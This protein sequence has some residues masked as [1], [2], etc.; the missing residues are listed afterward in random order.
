MSKNSAFIH[1]RVHSSYSLLEGAI[2]PQGMVELSDKYHM[3][4]VAITDTGN[5]FGSLEFSQYC[6]KNGVQPIVGCLLDID[7]GEKKGAF[8]TSNNFDK[9]LL[10]AKNNQGY[11]NLLELVSNSF[12]KTGNDIR[13]HIK[14]ADLDIL[15]EGLIALTGSVGGPVNRFILEKRPAEAENILLRLHAI[16]EDRLYIE[17]CRHGLKDEIDSEEEL[18][19]LAYKHNIPLVATNDVFFADQ[20]V[21]KAHDA[22]L[23]IAG[24]RYVT[25]ADR[26]TATPEHYFKSTREMVALFSD[27]PEAVEN[28]IN[29]A[30]RCSVMSEGRNPMLPHFTCEEGR[31]EAE[32][33]K[34][35][36]AAGLQMRL[37][38]VVFKGT[39]TDIEKETISKTYFDRLEYELGVIN[40]MDFPGYFLIVSDFI[41]WSKRNNIPVGPGRGSGAGSVVAWSLDITDLDPL[42]FGL[43]FERFL[44][45]ERISMPDFDIDFCQER[46][47]EVIRY[48]QGK[49]GRDKVAQIITFGKLQARAVIRDVG[50]V[51]QMPY[52]QIDRISKMIP[53]NPIDPVTLS[54]AISMDR[55]FKEMINSDPEISELV[56]ISLKLEGLNRHASTHAAG[57][58]IADRPLYELVPVY[59]DPRSD[60]PV[61]GYSMKYAEGAGL[62]KFDFLGLKTLTVI[63]KT[64]DLIAQKN[65]HIDIS[66]I[67][68]EDEKTF[69]ML[70][71]GDSVGVF[72]LESAGMRD[73][74]RK[75]QPDNVDDIIA[76][77]SL[78]RPGPMDNIPSYIARKHGL[79]EVDYMHPTLEGTLKETYGVIIYQEQVMQIA[80]VMGGY[81]LGA[82]DLLRRAMGKKIA[83]EMDAQ[84][85][86][87]VDG[88]IKNKVDK[89]KASSI[90][91]LVAKFA[92]YGFNKS[93]AAAY[94]MISYQTAYLKAHYPVEFLAAS[95]NLEINDTDKINTFR[96]ETLTQG[97]KMLP[98]DINKSN[99]YFKPEHVDGDEFAIR[100]GLGALKGVGVVA[101]EVLEKERIKNGDYK[102]VFDLASRIESNVMNKRQM[103]S[104]VK[105]GSFD[106]L[107]PNRKQL[108]EIIEQIMRYSAMVNSEKNSSQFG[109]FGGAAHNDT[110]KP[111][112]PQVTD[113]PAMERMNNE[114]QAVGLYLNEH[115]VSSYENVLRKINVIPFAEMAA[116]LSDGNSYIK[117]AGVLISKRMRSSP[118]GRFATISMSDPSGI[119]EVSIFNEDL[120][121]SAR[122]ILENGSVLLIDVEARKDDGGIRM[123]ASTIRNLE[124]AVYS[125]RLIIHMLDTGRIDDLKKSLGEKVKGKTQISII[126]YTASHKVEI[127]LPD[128]YNIRSS[129]LNDIRAI[130]GIKEVEEI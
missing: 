53:F 15:G 112:L 41:R 4:A 121:S 37:E 14:I 102:D 33:L 124:D 2:T 65:I 57:V 45:P 48:V 81:S 47:E 73:T 84:R 122:D 16:F 42:R 43:L 24:G 46:R 109:L 28:T 76:L 59:R 108:F 111:K 27:I 120:L 71:K 58:V 20:S 36:A 3:P 31:T 26:R 85:K 129:V 75:M 117:I 17:L 100:Y 87:F 116:K 101:M 97:I 96:Q 83:S 78:Y 12:L 10:L 99:A 126:A 118:K 127:A 89:A 69:E 114:F 92:G 74:L 115:P 23:C 19:K 106:S 32:E 9:I 128:S 66:R 56:G 22:L 55:V 119:F 52:G 5:L 49:Y 123:T 51:L 104:L 91:D 67:P 77:I 40:N 18:I 125:S 93:H 70:S 61:C 68:L 80:Q 64:C 13:P 7:I 38:T 39:E 6:S 8:A 86:I 11:K 72:Q 50:R 107:H 95:M 105:S 44:N 60:M 30:K 113:W 82:A 21:Y 1:L 94:A 130:K 88:A 54:K 103:E 29:I 25:E 110:A 34:A 79:E 63:A 62:V 35:T 98:P 90:F